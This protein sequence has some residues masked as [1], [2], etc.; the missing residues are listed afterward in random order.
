MI[1]LILTLILLP[2][3]GSL[4]V[5]TSKKGEDNAYNVSVFTLISNVIVILGL[6]SQIDTTNNDLQFVLSYVWTQS[7][8]IEINLGIDTF[9]LILLLGIYIALLIGL[10]GLNQYAKKNKS[11][12]IQMLYFVFN[13]TG[14][15]ISADII[16]FYIFFSGI[17]IPLFM[18][19]GT[20]TNT[21]KT[22]NIY[23]FFIYNFVGVYFNFMIKISN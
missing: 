7:I 10:I 23:R 15:L 6:F 11:L 19:I 5:L 20:Q 3:I 1:E 2:L 4:F 17:L 12:L 13:I 18:L 14:L 9:S 21:K 8:N 16:S 22:L